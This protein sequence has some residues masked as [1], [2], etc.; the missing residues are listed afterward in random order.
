[1]S[2]DDDG[3]V[4]T[5]TE[6]ETLTL[7][8]ASTDDPWLAQQ[9]A[10]S[11]EPA[12]RGPSRHH[13]GPAGRWFR[14]WAGVMLVADGAGLAIAAFAHWMWLAVLGKAALAAGVGVIW[15]QRAFVVPKTRVAVRPVAGPPSSPPPR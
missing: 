9:L 2:G 5:E 6:L 12:A 10:G 11:D 1:V 13:P 14:R 15:S 3:V 7:L 8:A 4:L